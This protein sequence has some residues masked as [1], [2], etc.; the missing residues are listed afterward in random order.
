MRGQ[1]S[2][3]D[4][5]QK[6]EL[7]L[8]LIDF[9]DPAANLFHVTDEWEYTNSRHTNRADF[10]AH[11]HWVREQIRAL[12]FHSAMASWFF[13][14]SSA[15]SFVCAAQPSMHRSKP[16]CGQTGWRDATRWS[17]LETSPGRQSCQSPRTPVTDQVVRQGAQRINVKSNQIGLFLTTDIGPPPGRFLFACSTGLTTR[18]R[19]L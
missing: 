19:R 12:Q 4:P 2:L 10:D 8:V 3:Y 13:S 17:A 7:N 5:A 16:H 9:E 14:R 1:K 15:P 6:R 11:S 18:R